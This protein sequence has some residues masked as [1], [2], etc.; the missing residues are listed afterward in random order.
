MFRAKKE[1]RWAE[2]VKQLIQQNADQAAAF[3]EE[4]RS[5]LDRIQ[6][7]EKVQLVPDPN[8]TPAEQPDND[9]PE[10]AKV[11]TIEY[12]PDEETN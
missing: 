1:D 2:I 12:G 10:M 4:R 9:A 3:E 11:G 8:W 7:P 6:H 5:L